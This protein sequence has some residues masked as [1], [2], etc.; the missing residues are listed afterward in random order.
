V[1]VSVDTGGKETAETRVV[2]TYD[3]ELLDI[4]RDDIVSSGL[5]PVINVESAGGG[6]IE[7]SF[8]VTAEAGYAPVA[9]T[10]EQAVAKFTFRVRDHAQAVTQIR[11]EY[12]GTDPE[13]SGIF[14][15]PEKGGEITN[16]L[17]STEGLRIFLTK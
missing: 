4:S 6:R 15:P 10:A 1:T 14:T 2:V 3:P 16:I 17:N 12:D 8:F 7:A 11:L 9:V 5:Y 13:L